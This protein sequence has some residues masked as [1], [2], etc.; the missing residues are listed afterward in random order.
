[1]TPQQDAGGDEIRMVPPGQEDPELVRGHAAAM[2][3][4]G[5]ERRGQADKDLKAL[6]KMYAKHA[7][8]LE[9]AAAK[10][11]FDP[12]AAKAD[13]EALKG[14]KAEDEKQAE[15]VG[16]RFAEVGRKHGGARD[17]LLKEAGV[18][19]DSLAQEVM[20][21]VTLPEHAR[22]VGR[23][24]REDKGRSGG[25]RPDPAQAGE[26]DDLGWIAEVNG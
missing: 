23:R 15:E 11:G 17:N 18:E 24:G 19:P 5:S 10:A 13:L 16:R 9:K 21:T 7:K 14:L 22:A 12:A 2:E 6:E 26:G 1:M 8:R 4:L 20:S 3:Q 25:K